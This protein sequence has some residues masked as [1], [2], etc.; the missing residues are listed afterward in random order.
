MNA[1]SSTERKRKRRWRG[2]EG[3]EQSCEREKRR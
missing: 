2:E 3:R 1:T